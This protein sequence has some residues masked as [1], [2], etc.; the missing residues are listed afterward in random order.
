MDKKTVI[1]IGP[2]K[3]GSSL[4]LA[5]RQKSSYR[6]YLAGFKPLVSRFA[7]YIPQDG[8]IELGLKNRLQHVDALIFT[9][10]DDAIKPAAEAVR[11]LCSTCSI[12]VHTSGALDSSQLDVLKSTGVQT[13]SWHP[14]QTFTKRFLDQSFWQGI[15]TTFEGDKEA[16]LFIGDLCRHLGCRLIHIDRRQKPA[17]HIASVFCANFLPALLS[18]GLSILKEEGF[19][20]E[21]GKSL[22]LPLMRKSLKNME[23]NPFEKALSGPLQRADI[24]TLQ[25]HTEFLLQKN[26]PQLTEIYRLLSKLLAGDKQLDIN[27]R[28]RVIQW[29]KKES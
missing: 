28:E 26:M 16:E 3:V 24:G 21:Q 12:T 6:V 19:T 8:Y 7:R 1:I 10:P 11:P 18:A 17:L 22:L 20:P 9:V 13:G 4:F 14:L 15:T 23:E 27:D 5:L 2:G 29:L 25:R